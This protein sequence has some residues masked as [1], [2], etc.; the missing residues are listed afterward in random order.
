MT[1][2]LA[3]H[4]EVDESAKTVRHYRYAVERMTRI[5]AG[6]MALTPELSAK[7][8]MG[9]HVW[10]NAQHADAWGRRL[11]E[12]R[13][14]AQVSEPAN[15]RL[16]AFLDAVE[17]AERP[18]QTIERV[19]AIYRVLKPHLLATYEVH[20]ASANAVY[21]PPTCRILTRC[22]EDERRHVA[23]GETILR[24]L[25][26]A[27]EQEAR[28]RA[29]EARLWRLLEAAGG[30]TGAGPVARAR[31]AAAPP[32]PLS[33]DAAEFIRL[34]QSAGTWPIAPALA[35]ALSGFGDALIAGD[36]SVARRWLAPEVEL[37]PDLQTRLR[38]A[39]V[40]RQS[41]V[42]CARVGEQRLVK[43]RLDGARDG[44]T[45]L[46]RWVPSGSDWRIA[47]LEPVA[48]APPRPA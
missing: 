29:C 15:A 35:Q 27:P 23:A 16:V 39:Q 34:E 47:A 14:A 44:V 28:A 36:A 2:P 13:A 6:W 33:D 24:H 37:G 8:L 5:L 20:L 43:L 31:T 38:G 18:E 22:I 25:L 30:V 11:P 3:G 42:A 17:A 48:A 1:H 45:L 46:L 41:I 21:E 40:S 7:L 12:L 10:D 26:R 9:R 32:A 4:L 19:V